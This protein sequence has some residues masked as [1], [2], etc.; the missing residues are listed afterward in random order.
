MTRGLVDG[1][2]NKVSP[3]KNCIICPKAKQTRD[4]FPTTPTVRAPEKLAL[5]H[6]DVYQVTDTV[7]WKGFKYFVTFIGDYSRYTM[8]S[9]LKTK[10]EVL[11]KFKDYKAF[12]EKQT[13]KQ[14]KCLRTDNGGEYKSLEFQNF[15]KTEGIMR[16]F[17]N[18]NTPEQKRSC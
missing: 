8:V 15:V 6:S 9:F 5:I 18:S 7:S 17:S 14:I 1:I 11:Q 16:Q 4:S 3:P 13:G 12:V 2:D 10:D